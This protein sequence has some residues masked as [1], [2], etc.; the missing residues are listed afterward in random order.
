MAESKCPGCGGSVRGLAPEVRKALGK[1]CVCMACGCHPMEYVKAKA[2]AELR[3]KFAA[4]VLTGLI[5]SAHEWKF[6]SSEQFAR[7]AYSYADAM[8]AERGKKK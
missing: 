7:A 8:I 5:T 6:D 2:G 4:A 3:D 1:D